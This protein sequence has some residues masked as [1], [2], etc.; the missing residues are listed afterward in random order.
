[1]RC[2]PQKYNKMT[3]KGWAVLHIIV[4]YHFILRRYCMPFFPTGCSQL[5]DIDPFLR[6]L[7]L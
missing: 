3:Q 1:M 2:H 6:H 7:L 4:S 5:A